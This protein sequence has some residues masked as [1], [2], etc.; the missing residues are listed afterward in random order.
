MKHLVFII[1]PRSGVDRQKAI[2]TLIGEYLDQ[3]VYSFEIRY[4]EYARHGTE[5]AKDAALKG[6]FAVVAV[7]GDGS[8][9]DIVKGLLGTPTLLGIIPMGSG[10]GMARSLGIPLDIRKAIA[11]LN[12]G[13]TVKMDVGYANEHPFLSNAGVAFD[14]LIAKAFQNSTRRGLA[15]YSALVSRHLW[16]YREQEWSIKAD[17]QEIEETAFMINIANGR[18]FGYNF[19]IA[20]GASSTDG[21]FDVVVIRKFPKM[22]GALLALQLRTGSILRSGWVRRLHAR[23]VVVSRKGLE[24]MQVDGDPVA[25]KDSVRFTLSPGAQGVLVP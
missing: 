11:V 8:V 25:C 7:G 24:L 6:A 20:P 14:A 13:R 1:N 4:T 12:Q 15:A 16:A 10:N 22:F 17:D 2:Q 19:Q 3:Q 23:E 9:N 18:Q 21:L 5:L